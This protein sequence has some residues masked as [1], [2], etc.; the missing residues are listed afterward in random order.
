LALDLP[1]S[2][3][4]LAQSAACERSELRAYACTFGWRTARRPYGTHGGRLSR[5]ICFSMPSGCCNPADCGC[6]ARADR[7]E[8]RRR[9]TDDVSRKLGSRPT[10]ISTVGLLS[11]DT[12]TRGSMSRSRMSQ[13]SATTGVRNSEQSQGHPCSPSGDRRAFENARWRRWIGLH[14][15]PNLSAL[16]FTGDFLDCPTEFSDFDSLHCD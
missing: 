9:A 5:S 7:R 11:T 13:D 16:I 15:S 10:H 14:T 12:I 2:M 6:H 1:R 8:V 3:P 4:W